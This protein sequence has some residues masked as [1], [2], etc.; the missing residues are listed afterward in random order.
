M[1]MSSLLNPY[2]LLSIPGITYL[3][4]Y[5]YLSLYHRQLFLFNTVIHE[6][7]AYTLLQTIFYSSHFLGHIPVHT[8][9]AFIF[10]GLYLS[11]GSSGPKGKTGKKILVISILMAIFMAA[12][13]YLSC[14]EFGYEDTLSF[15]AQEKQAVNIYEDGGSWNLHLPSTM[16][17]FLLIP[18]Y[19][20]FIKRAFRREV[21]IN[22]SGY[23][24]AAAGFISFFIFTY[25]INKDISEAFYKVW[26]EPR[27]LAHSV[28]EV[29]TFPLTYFPI[30]LSILLLY[31]KSGI[32]L[33][34]A[35]IPA[36]LNYFMVTLAAV[37][38]SAMIYQ[39][40][41]PLTVGIGS[42]AQKPAFADGG[43]LS[44]PYLLASHYFEH[45]LDTVYF[46]LLCLLLYFAAGKRGA[47]SK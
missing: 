11:L 5:V 46:S 4:S 39:A 43:R 35:D 10:A 38:F 23:F 30:P 25:I 34:Q 19:I 15:L 33:K 1:N 42:L 26:S 45:F 44:V 20:F 16:I 7:G 14:E 31:E 18:A 6:G 2:L 37:F 9:L 29:A 8:V 24:Y 3:L 41:V 17:F 36:A 22:G 27:Y 47:G 13:Y 12:A 28:R 32:R 40:Y 21:S